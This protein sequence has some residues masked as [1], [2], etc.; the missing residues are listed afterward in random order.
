MVS[1]RRS[2][3]MFQVYAHSREGGVFKNSDSVPRRL[4]VL[5]L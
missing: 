2:A 5:S 3:L 1:G 4:V